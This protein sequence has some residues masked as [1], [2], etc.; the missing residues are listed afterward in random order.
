MRGSDQQSGDLSYVDIDAR[1]P[2]R[3]PLRAIRA[4]VN[5]CLERLYESGMG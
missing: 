5:E 1:V 2:V 4:I 3:H